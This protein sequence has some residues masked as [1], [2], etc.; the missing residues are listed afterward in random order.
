MTYVIYDIGCMGPL[1]PGK[2]NIFVISALVKLHQGR[3]RNENQ[4]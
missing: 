4:T 3:R 2:I 1:Y